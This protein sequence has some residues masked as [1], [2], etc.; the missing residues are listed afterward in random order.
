MTEVIEKDQFHSLTRLPRGQ[1]S[2]SDVPDD[3][4]NQWQMYTFGMN[5]R[6]KAESALTFATQTCKWHGD[7]DMEKRGRNVRLSYLGIMS[8]TVGLKSAQDLG[9]RCSGNKDLADSRPLQFYWN[10]WFCW[11]KESFEPTPQ[12]QADSLSSS[13]W[14]LSVWQQPL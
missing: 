5:H 2:S 10:E 14:W 1:W 4:Y 8:A 9:K 11:D 7:K 13:A 12:F 3:N 6:L